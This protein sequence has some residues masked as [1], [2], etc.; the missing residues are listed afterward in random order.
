MAYVYRH[1]G[2]FHPQELQLRCLR[3]RRVCADAE[4]VAA[5]FFL[6]QSQLVDDLFGDLEDRRSLLDLDTF[7]L[8]CL[9]G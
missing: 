2:M 7:Q 4:L 1:V 9:N 6:Q 3:A 8:L 5:L